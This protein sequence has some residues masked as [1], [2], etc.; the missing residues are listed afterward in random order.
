M[1]RSSTFPHQAI[2]KFRNI[3]EQIEDKSG[4]L[5]TLLG[6]S[7]STV[8]FANDDTQ[9]QRHIED[10]HET[11][12]WSGPISQ[13]GCCKRLLYAYKLHAPAEWRE[14]VEELV[15]ALKDLTA[16][17]AWTISSAMMK[18][19][20]PDIYYHTRKTRLAFLAKKEGKELAFLAKKEGKEE[21]CEKTESSESDSESTDSS[22]YSTY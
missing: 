1:L 22:S 7:L 8:W 21:L 12:L 3:Y 4:L 19:L 6:I 13:L 5:M 17:Q 14:Q 18:L 20:R 11:T 16:A 2:S 9:R 10:I 15:A